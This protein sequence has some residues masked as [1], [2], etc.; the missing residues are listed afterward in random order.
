MGRF[1]LANLFE[2]EINIEASDINQE[3]LDRLENLT[4]KLVRELKHI[5]GRLQ[6]DSSRVEE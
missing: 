4:G 6:V 3:T 5:R 2:E 1:S